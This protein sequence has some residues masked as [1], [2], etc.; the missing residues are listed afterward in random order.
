MKGAQKLG[1]RPQLV[2][3][4]ITTLYGS[5][6][7]KLYLRENTAKNLIRIFIADAISVTRVR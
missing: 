3:V 5:P 7:T 4:N 6:V 2:F 1:Y